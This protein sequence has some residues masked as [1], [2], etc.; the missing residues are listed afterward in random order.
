M[1]LNENF[2]DFEQKSIEYYNQAKLDFKKEI[3]LLDSLKSNNLIS[4]TNYLYR[5]DALKM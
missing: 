2:K 1:F 5:K 4:Q 3:K